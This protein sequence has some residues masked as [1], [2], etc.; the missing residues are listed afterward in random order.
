MDKLKHSKLKGAYVHPDVKLSP[1]SVQMAER[2]GNPGHLRTASDKFVP[3]TNHTDLDRLKGNIAPGKFKPA[4]AVMTGLGVGLAATAA[5]VAMNTAQIDELQTDVGNLQTNVAEL[6]EDF[7]N[8]QCGHECTNACEHVCEHVCEVTKEEF[9]GHVDQSLEDGAHGGAGITTDCDG[10]TN[11]RIG[12]KDFTIPASPDPTVPP[13]QPPG[14]PKPTPGPTPPGTPTPGPG[15]T[16]EPPPPP[17]PPK[18]EV[19]IVLP[20]DDFN[21]P[22]TT[23]P[24]S[25]EVIIDPTK[26]GYDVIIGNNPGSQPAPTCPTSDQVTLDPNAGGFDAST[27]VTIIGAIGAGA[28]KLRNIKQSNPLHAEPRNREER[29]KLAKRTHNTRGQWDVNR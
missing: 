28:A 12:D 3:A 22:P 8:F 17:P 24:P 1:Q 2:T 5:V 14:T 11:I 18:D 15:P 7:N 27:G 16:P 25:D 23:C 4:S 13:T 20:G 10:N 26:G 19:I 6:R 29:R 9:E 21:K